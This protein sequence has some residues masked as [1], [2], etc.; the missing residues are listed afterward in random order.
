MYSAILLT[1]GEMLWRYQWNLFALVCSLRPLST[2]WIFCLADLSIEV[3]GMLI[4]PTMTVF[5]WTSPFI[6][7]KIRCWCTKMPL[8]SEYWLFILLFFQIHLLGQIVFW[9]VYRIFYVHYHVIC[10]QWQFGFLL[11]NLDDFYVFFFS[12]CCG[13]NS[14][15]I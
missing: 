7:I 12:D 9:W 15:T 4:S 2:C 1:W 5:L 14:N 8:I 3:R 11:S 13:R 10:K 6:S